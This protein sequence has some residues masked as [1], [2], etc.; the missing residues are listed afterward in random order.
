MHILK[1]PYGITWCDNIIYIFRCIKTARMKFYLLRCFDVFLINLVCH[2]HTA[3]EFKEK[4][5][6]MTRS[7]GNTNVFTK[8]FNF[9][10]CEGWKW[11]CVA[12]EKDECGGKRGRGAAAP[13]LCEPSIKSCRSLNTAKWMCEQAVLLC[14]MAA[15]WPARRKTLLH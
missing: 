13:L 7:E 6:K 5:A 8:M 15:S 12:L 2:T 10:P 1:Y 14:L 9:S 4:T 11:T 3:A